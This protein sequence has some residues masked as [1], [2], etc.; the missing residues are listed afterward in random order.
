MSTETFIDKTIVQVKNVRL[1][2]TKL[3]T[4]SFVNIAASDALDVRQWALVR[5]GC[6]DDDDTVLQTSVFLNHSTNHSKVFDDTLSTILTAIPGDWIVITA[7]KHEPVF[8]E[9]VYT[10]SSARFATKEEINK[11]GKKTSNCDS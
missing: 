3:S 10:L 6:D 7:K 8:G 5:V 9:A 4:G 1:L 11:Y 2:Q